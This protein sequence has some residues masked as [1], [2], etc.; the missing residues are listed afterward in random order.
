MVAGHFMLLAT[1]LVQANP[2]ATTLHVDI[3][4]FHLQGRTNTG[5]GVDHETDERTITQAHGCSDVNR[6][7]K[8]SGLLGGEDGWHRQ[9]ARTVPEERL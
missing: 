1:L 8:G 7:N 4:D 5:K 3:F 2:S 9:W 6:V